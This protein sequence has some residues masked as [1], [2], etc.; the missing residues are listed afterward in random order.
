MREGDIR[1]FMESDE[2][3]A[4]LRQL[5]FKNIEVGFNALKAGVVDLRSFIMH[6]NKIFIEFSDF[7]NFDLIIIF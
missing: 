5:V 6:R 3:R 1:R 7:F 2:E 4:C